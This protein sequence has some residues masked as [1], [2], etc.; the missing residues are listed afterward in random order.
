MTQVIATS[1]GGLCFAAAM[2][3][4]AIRDVGTMRIRNALVLFL[5]AAYAL[6]APLSGQGVAPIGL[7]AGFAA[8]I[9]V[10]MMAFFT[11]GWIGGGD[12]KLAAVASLWLGPAQAFP[13]LLYTALFG[14]VL[15][16]VILQLRAVPLPAHCRSIPWIARLHDPKSR[17]PY[18]VAIASGA[19]YVLPKTHWMTVAF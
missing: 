3:W 15:T 5:L 6:L 7:S 12:A 19:L 1:L 9:L 16:L 11:L 17:I 10:C 13:Y 18:G 2:V 4:A 8:L 14:G